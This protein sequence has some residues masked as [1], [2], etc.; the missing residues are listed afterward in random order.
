MMFLLLYFLSI[1]IENLLLIKWFFVQ[2]LLRFEAL[3]AYDWEIS[4]I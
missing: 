1:L 3:K 2:E 4:R